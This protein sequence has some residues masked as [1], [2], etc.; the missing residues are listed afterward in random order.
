MFR[1]L[2]ALAAILLLVTGI[3]LG[4]SKMGTSGATELRIPVGTRAT[5]MAGAVVA[6]VTG[7]EALFWNP[8]GAAGV[9][10]TE[11]YVSYRGYIADTYLTYF[12]LVSSFGYGTVGVHA[13]ILNLGDIY[14]TTEDAWDGT[15][16]VYTVNIPVLGLS[17]AR[18]LTDRV[19]V[20]ATAMYI[21]EEIMDTSARGMAFDF[22]FQ[23]VPGWKTLRLGMAMKNYGPRMRY[24]GPGFEHSVKVPGDDPEASNRILSLESADFE[25]PSYFQLG[26]SYDFQLAQNGMLRTGLDF[27]SNN[28]SQDE[29]RLGVEY[30]LQKRFYL[31]GGYVYCD[32]D[33]YLYGATFGVGVDFSLGQTKAAVNYTHN[34]INDYFDDVSEIS[35]V[36]GF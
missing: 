30:V 2:F 19:S 26:V 5:A 35:L 27:Q 6:D 9:T 4:N 32:Q 16:E 34:F 21:S 18:A 31:R 29:Y 3:A 12:G 20:G 1:K 14:V 8:A 17:Y 13:K 15:G 22:G 11:A 23:Y 25:L 24:N 33:D 28:F 7:T 36:F 10:G